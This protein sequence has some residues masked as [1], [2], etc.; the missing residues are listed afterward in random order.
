[1]VL[2]LRPPGPQH[3]SSWP[4]GDPGI[5]V[6]TSYQHHHGHA[7]VPSGSEKESEQG[8]EN[9]GVRMGGR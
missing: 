7:V 5:G 6:T 4:I 8:S 9:G 1:V 3:A 2:C